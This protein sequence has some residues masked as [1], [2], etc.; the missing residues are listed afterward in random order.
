MFEAGRISFFV[1]I[2]MWL[3]Q[4]F[5]R[6]EATTC[7]PRNTLSIPS[8]LFST[9]ADFVKGAVCRIYWHL[10]VGLL[11]ATLPFL[12]QNWCVNGYFS[13]RGNPARNSWLRPHCQKTRLPTFFFFCLSHRSQWRSNLGGFLVSFNQSFKPHA[14]WTLLEQRWMGNCSFD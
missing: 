9:T 1:S 8:Q 10:V 3:M 5:W 13:K 14:D 4:M 6:G 12:C 7:W 2:H 11:I